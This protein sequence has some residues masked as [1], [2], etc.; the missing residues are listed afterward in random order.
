[1][2]RLARFMRCSRPDRR[3]LSEALALLCCARILIRAVPF[4]WIVPH[5]GRPMAESPVD[6]GE[7]QRQI[8]L[9]V[10]WAVQAVASHVPLGFVCMPQALAAKWMLRR[11]RL[12]ST[13]Y[14]GL[15]QQKE[16]GMT[17]HAWLRVGDMILTGRHESSNHTVVATFAEE[18]T[19]THRTP[20]VAVAPQPSLK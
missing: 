16:C 1:M 13:L 6:V 4:R 18:T 17:A 15:Q 19:P 10:A 14:L 3:L 2:N 7:A 20:A 12:P 11:R 9:R 8:A 5:L